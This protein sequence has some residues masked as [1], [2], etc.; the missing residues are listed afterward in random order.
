MLSDHTREEPLP[1]HAAGEETPARPALCPRT[2]RG[3]N[4]HVSRGPAHT[5]RARWRMEQGG[6]ALVSVPDS[7]RAR[8]MRR[9]RAGEG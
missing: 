3:H 9:R 4:T 5:R 1:V 7:W 6:G 2:V 8:R